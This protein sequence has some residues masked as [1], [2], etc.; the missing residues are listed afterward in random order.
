MHEDDDKPTEEGAPPSRVPQPGSPV[1]PDPSAT[2]T[3]PAEPAPEIPTPPEPPLS[4]DYMRFHEKGGIVGGRADIIPPPPHA[5]IV[6]EEDTE[7]LGAAAEPSETLDLDG[8]SVPVVPDPDAQTV[9]LTED[10]VTFDPLRGPVTR[11]G[12]PAG[13]AEL[14]VGALTVRNTG[15]DRALAASKLYDALEECRNTLKSVRQERDDQCD[16]AFQAEEQLARLEHRL[17]R[18]KSVANEPS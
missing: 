18:I 3:P 2:L 14:L 11:A 4:M 16:R 9:V 5:T 8:P 1:I 12:L 6:P 15:E 17:A 7:P 13:D 10:A